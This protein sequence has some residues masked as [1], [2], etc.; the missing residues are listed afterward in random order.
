M[1]AIEKRKIHES[2][3]VDD[4]TLTSHRFESSKLQY[5]KQMM[6]QYLVSRDEDV[7]NH[8]EVAFESIFQ[9]SQKEREA[10]EAR[11]KESVQDTLAS[12][13]SYLSLGNK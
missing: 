7:R 4:L 2:H 8:L 1:N 9:F 12:I 6:Y 10:I 3:S 5:I 11:R 13:S